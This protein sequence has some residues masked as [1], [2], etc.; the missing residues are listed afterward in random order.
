MQRKYYLLL[1][2][3]AAAYIALV[4]AA[5]VDQAILKKYHISTLGLYLLDIAIL[6][7]LFAIWYIAFFGFIN[8]K[9]YS[10]LIKDDED[11]QGF[12]LIGHGLAILGIG[13]V[14]NSIISRIVDIITYHHLDLV[15]AGVIISNYFTIILALASYWYIYQGSQKL[16]RVIPR[17]R[18]TWHAY[19]FVILFALGGLLF[20][21]SAATNPERSAPATALT[22]GIYYLPQWLIVST[23]VIPSLAAWFLGLLAVRNIAHFYHNIQGV[24]Y[25][26]QLKKV[27][28]GLG[29][30]ITTSVSVQI[31]TLFS[32]STSE[33]SLSLLL[34]I[35][36]AL[37]TVTASGFIMVAMGAKK[38]LQ[39]EG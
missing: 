16:I 8:M 7:P 24:I 10:T 1:L 5:P 23:V 35:I 9:L 28:Q 27:A 34:L 17:R 30:I 13:M 22:H 4:F 25:R 29:I 6:I 37:L 20:A 11:G 33:L 3:L 36:F 39:L 19:L 15:P 12:H 26:S 14:F 38:L 18:A 32:K 31:L 2:G 21:Y